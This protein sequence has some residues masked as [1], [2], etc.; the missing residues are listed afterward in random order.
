MPYIEVERGVSL[1]CED[2]GVGRP[3]V[4]VHGWPYTHRIFEYQM[5]GLAM[6]GYRVV[7]LDLRGFGRSDKPWDGNNYDTWADDIGH[8]MKHLH[9]RDVLLVGF[10]MGGGIVAHFAG[11]RDD[12]RVTGLALLDAAAPAVAAT[13][14]AR[15]TLQ[16]FI[17]AAA[18]DPAKFIHEFNLM[19]V[20]TQVS[21]E[22]LRWLDLIGMQASLRA[23]L[24][25]ADELRDRDLSSELG[26]IRVP[27][28][29]LHGR[30][31]KIVPFAAAEAQRRMITNSILIPFDTSGHA[32]FW[33][34]KDRLT[35][36]LARFAAAGMEAMAA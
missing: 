23:L 20:N 10:S 3:I 18:D 28:R 6:Q 15:K 34:A 17:D 16:G 7:G 21:A 4:F 26:N 22:Y 5:R 30:Q 8:V 33:D 27:T 13:L 29:I 9:L 1:F 31:D 19:C 35:E 14:A 25:G 2:W 12:S 36:E 32:I 11:T 24:R